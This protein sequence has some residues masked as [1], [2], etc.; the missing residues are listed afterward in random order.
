MSFGYF[1]A[2]WTRVSLKRASVYVGIIEDIPV[3]DNLNHSQAHDYGC[4]GFVWCHPWGSGRSFSRTSCA[5]MSGG[6]LANSKHFA[7]RSFPARRSRLSQLWKLADCPTKSDKDLETFFTCQK[8]EARQSCNKTPP[9]SGMLFYQITS[10]WPL[11][12]IK[13]NGHTN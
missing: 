11:L 1:F 8:W 10:N 3:M 2:K 6:L 7:R 12:P 4:G 13:A 5:V 9:A